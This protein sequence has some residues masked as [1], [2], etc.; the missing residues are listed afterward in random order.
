[1]IATGDV[2][3]RDLRSTVVVCQMENLLQEAIYAVIDLS[4][5]AHVLGDTI[6]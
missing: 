3:V 4:M 2:D 6:I 5:N 1:M